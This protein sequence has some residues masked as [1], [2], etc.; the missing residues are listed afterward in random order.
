MFIF[1]KVRSLLQKITIFT[2]T[3]T[4]IANAG[5]DSAKDSICVNSK[6]KVADS[7][8]GPAFR[9]LTP[10]RMG[11]LADVPI[12]LSLQRRSPKEILLQKAKLVNTNRAST[13]T[14]SDVNIG[15][16]DIPVEIIEEEIKTKLYY[17]GIIHTLKQECIVRNQD[18]ERLKELEEL[19]N[20]LK[21]TR[22]KEE[23]LWE[24]VKFQEMSLEKAR[25]TLQLQFQSRRRTQVWE[26]TISSEA[27]TLHRVSCMFSFRPQIACFLRSPTLAM[28]ETT[29]NT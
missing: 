10:V 11:R 22:S 5:G 24:E 15:N 12:Q 23:R 29:L 25:L 7:S 16:R 19:R 8:P 3:Y 17:L 4:M 27:R 1:L 6:A 21:E 13:S 2:T 9:G 20:T 18:D 28:E 14:S 26:W